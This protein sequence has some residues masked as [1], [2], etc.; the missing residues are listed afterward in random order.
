[1]T[2]SRE[3]HL[4]RRPVGLPT[5]D[6]FELVTVDLPAPGPGQVLVKNLYLSVDPYMRGRMVDRKSYT[7]PFQL[8]EAMT[9]GAVGTVAASNHA[10]FA[11]GDTVLSMLGW[12]EAFLSDGRGLTKVD[13][14]LAPVESYLGVMGMPG[15]T[16]YFGLL[17][18]GAPQPGETVFV[19]GAAGAVGSVVCQI[20]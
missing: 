18:I 5:A 12:R 11:V 19:S 4:K 17:D 20:A 6:A 8:G 16:A 9:G 15:M 2:H 10:D 3:V 14:T 7:P 1:M 13:P